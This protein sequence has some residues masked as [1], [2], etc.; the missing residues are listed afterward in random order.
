[1]GRVA[2]EVVADPAIEFGSN[3]EGYDWILGFAS[4]GLAPHTPGLSPLVAHHESSRTVDVGQPGA[5]RRRSTRCT[6]GEPHP[7]P[8]RSGGDPERSSLVV[9]RSPAPWHGTAAWVSG[10]AC[11]T[12]P[13]AQR[14][15]LPGTAG[16]L[17]ASGGR[18]PLGLGGNTRRPAEFEHPLHQEQRARH[19]ELRPSMSHESPL[20]RGLDPD[21]QGGSLTS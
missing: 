14:D 16:P 19:G 17:V 12:D 18:T 1:M 13:A 3:L 6:V 15:P 10:A 7:A 8:M 9:A 4:V 11:S 5:P 2:F 21:E 20:A